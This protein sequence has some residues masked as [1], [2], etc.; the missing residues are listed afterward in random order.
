MKGQKR[1]KN[2]K[3]HLVRAAT[4]YPTSEDEED[5]ITK[6]SQQTNQQRTKCR[7]LF[8]EICVKLDKSGEITSK[9]TGK[10][11]P[12][13]WNITCESTNLIYCIECKRCKM[14]YV[15]ENRTTGKIPSQRTSKCDKKKCRGDRCP[16]ALQSMR[17]PKKK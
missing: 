11:Y 4:S 7:K 14:Q 17:P 16:L 8:C 15:G 5:G 1:P 6:N 3:D 13:K 10:K 2:L 12:A 9:T